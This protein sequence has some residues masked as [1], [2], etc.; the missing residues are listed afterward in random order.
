MVP[1]KKFLNSLHVKQGTSL[2]I[3]LINNSI[4]N[5]YALKTIEGYG[6]EELTD[7]PGSPVSPLDPDTPSTPC[8]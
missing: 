7:F 6:N 1:G 4:F 3:T 8:R 2:G 5:D